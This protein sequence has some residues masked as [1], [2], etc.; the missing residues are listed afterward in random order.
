MFYPGQIW[1]DNNKNPI[2]AHGGCM[3]HYGGSY[4]WYGE[5]KGGITR[6]QRVDFIGISC[7]SS[8]DLYHWKNEGVVL[9]AVPDDPQ[10]DLH[11]SQVVER[12]KVLYHAQS[13]MFIMWMH[14]DDPTYHKACVG[15]AVSTAP[16]GP[17]EYRGSFR[18]NGVDS[19]DMT[20]FQDDDGTAYCIHSSDWNRTLVI[21]RLTEDY[22]GLTGDY[23][24]IFIDQKRE[25]PVV[26]KYQGRYYMITSFCTGW[27]PNP[28]L[29]A[30]S[31]SMMG[32]WCLVD[33]P[34]KAEGSETTYHSQ[35]ADAFWVAGEKTRCIFMADRWN[36]EDLGDSRYVWLP[37]FWD[38]DKMQIL[39]QD[40]WRL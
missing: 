21:A 29:Y 7:Y 25:A 4:Y 2:Q 15:V 11:P 34:C 38:G 28:A 16:T 18:P 9:P 14:V 1:R 35:G 32:N 33:N 20:L 22:M 17:F 24:R 30:V 13:G 36:P 3:L 37:I 10:H 40:E 5:N 8:Q 12:P 39:W 27:L 26:L 31:D 6:N 19:R 23:T